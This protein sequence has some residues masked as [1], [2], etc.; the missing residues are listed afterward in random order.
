VLPPECFTYAALSIINRLARFQ[1]F[2]IL[3]QFF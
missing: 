3:Q 2:H 1:N